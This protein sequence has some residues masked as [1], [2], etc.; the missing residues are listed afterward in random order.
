M[1]EPLQ[2][3]DEISFHPRYTER[4]IN[5]DPDVQAS[6]TDQDIGQNIA[7]APYTSNFPGSMRDIM[8]NMTGILETV[9][10]EIREMRSDRPEKSAVGSSNE[11]IQSGPIDRRTT[12]FG[13]DFD[14]QRILTRDARHGTSDSFTQ[15]QLPNSDRDPRSLDPSMRVSFEDQPTDIDQFSLDN[16]GSTEARPHTDDMCRSSVLGQRIPNLEQKEMHSEYN[17]HRDDLQHNNNA[18]RNNRTGQSPLARNYHR[19]HSPPSVTTDTGYRGR[20]T[21]CMPDNESQP[22]ACGDFYHDQGEQS[23]YPYRSS[24]HSEMPFQA[25]NVGFQQ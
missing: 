15:N 19:G 12:L 2:I 20:S 4:G 10:Q 23:Y 9:V 17:S 13:A 7:P 16:L 5:V 25:D 14:P 8:S 1:S 6:R 18:D 3:D 11:I 22:Q 24:S 21:A